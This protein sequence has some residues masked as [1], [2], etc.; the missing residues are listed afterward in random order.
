MAT[1][2]R[3]DNVQGPSFRD[4]SV[5][6]DSAARSFQAG[7][8]ALQQPLEQREA[9]NAVNAGV[10]R[11]NNTNAFLDAI[12]QYSDVDKLTQA[13]K[14][15]TIAALRGQYGNNID[16]NAVRSA[17][18]DRLTSLQTQG[19]QKIIYDNAMR[20]ENTAL[21]RDQLRTAILNGDKDGENAARNTLSQL[22][23]R[24]FATQT[25]FADQRSQELL[26]R[27][28][29]TT[30]FNQKVTKAADDHLTAAKALKV[31][32]AQINSAGASARASDSQVRYNQFNMD[33]QTTQDDA[34]RAAG[35]AAAATAALTRAG[36]LYA[37][38]GV[39]T[40]ST[41]QTESLQKILSTS[42]ANSEQ[43]A[44]V[45]A[46][47]QEIQK[48]GIKIT[49][50][51]GKSMTLREIPMA[52][53]S[54][55]ISGAYNEWGLRGWNKGFAESVEDQLTSNLQ[56][57]YVQNGKLTSRAADDLAAFKGVLQQSLQS[58]PAIL[59]NR[60][61]PAR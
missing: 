25:M 30:E 26:G 28:R 41:D 15:G 58:A 8:S 5:G 49:A 48:K 18:G 61:R 6:L 31:A 43:K 27:D 17:V 20:D 33:R 9:M 52:A 39:F 55:A 24:D 44:K 32:D 36:N 45:F 40:G 22:G 57:Q 37:A 16:A 19:T 60:P 47:L 2:I 56:S 50:P 34:A 10:Q 14:D 11:T 54:Q 46:R 23:Y 53:V 21:A 12:A 1:P 59:P 13:Q 51:D 7:L 42:D 3:W 38:D 29:A 35:R 4:A